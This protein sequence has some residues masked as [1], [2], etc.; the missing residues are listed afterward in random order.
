MGCPLTLHPHHGNDNQRSLIT[1]SGRKHKKKSILPIVVNEEKRQI[2][3]SQPKEELCGGRGGAGGGGSL[4]LL[5]LYFLSTFA[6]YFFLIK[7]I[8]LQ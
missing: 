7:G 5:L 8:E 1:L 6:L 3:F 2:G 4:L